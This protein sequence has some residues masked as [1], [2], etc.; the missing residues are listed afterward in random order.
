MVSVGI[1]LHIIGANNILPASPHAKSWFSKERMWALR[2]KRKH[3]ACRMAPQVE[4]PLAEDVLW[5]DIPF[6][7]IFETT[8]DTFW[9]HFWIDFLPKS[10]T[11]FG[12]LFWYPKMGPAI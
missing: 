3:G 9:A 8:V 7:C 5:Q 12:A 10:G 6:V 11:V 1:V 4:E 2:W